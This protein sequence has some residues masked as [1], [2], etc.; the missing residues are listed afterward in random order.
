MSVAAAVVGAYAVVG[1]YAV[2]DATNRPWAIA[3]GVIV[4][5]AIVLLVARRRWI[6]ADTGVVVVEVTGLWRRSWRLGDPSAVELEADGAG[7]VHLTVHD[8][9]RRSVLQIP[10]LADDLGGERALDP[11]ILRQVVDQLEP[12]IMSERVVLRLRAPSTTW[13]Q[14]DR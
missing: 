6:E 2:T 3:L 5:L 1:W 13:P 14:A 4:T 12:G 9:A 8:P 11:A 10:L 7:Q